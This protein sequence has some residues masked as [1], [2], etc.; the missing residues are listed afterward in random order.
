MKRSYINLAILLA[1]IFTPSSYS[2]AAEEAECPPGD[3]W[4]ACRA[5]AGDRGAMYAVGRNAYE[6]ARTSGDFTEALA[7]ARKLVG[8]GDKNGERLSKMVYMQLGWG[9][10]RDH[11]Q[12][13][14]WL[15][16]GI[17]GGEEYLVSWRK[18]LAEK[19]TPEQLADAKKMAGN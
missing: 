18:T 17:A 10:H 9:A 13:Y 1:I 14:V 4:I 2:F 15:S 16:E 5:Q 11:V 3:E 19:M 7:W 12:A 6:G 8:M